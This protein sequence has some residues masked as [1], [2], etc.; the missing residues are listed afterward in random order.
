MRNLTEGI[1]I[2][3]SLLALEGCAEDGL[4]KNN[5]ELVVYSD[6]DQT[7]E[8]YRRCVQAVY[9]ESPVVTMI[10]NPV[11]PYRAGFFKPVYLPN[12]KGELDVM[13]AEPRGRIA[14][15]EKVQLNEGQ[16]YAVVDNASECK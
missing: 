7:Q 13:V 15:R 3:A 8:A 9:T 11:V 16:T 10:G 1:A 6:V 2:A 4:Y 14:L 12:P 5:K